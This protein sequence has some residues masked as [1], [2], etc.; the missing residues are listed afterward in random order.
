M[1]GTPHI[2]KTDEF[3]ERFQTA[4]DPTP[5]IFGKLYCGFCDKIATK[6][7]M[8]IWR[9]CCVLYDPISHEMHVVQS[10]VMIEWLAGRWTVGLCGLYE[11]VHRICKMQ[12][13]P[14][15]L[16]LQVYQKVYQDKTER[17]C[18]TKHERKCET[19]VWKKPNQSN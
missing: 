1:L 12:I 17:V 7:H 15:D 4:F 6:V 11:D 19:K 14:P 8:F 10:R 3:L 13:I 2:S 18:K 16:F 9:D 5:L